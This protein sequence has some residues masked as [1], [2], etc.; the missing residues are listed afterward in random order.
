MDKRARPQS[1]KLPVNRGLNKNN[2]QSTNIT[3]QQ[4]FTN[5]RDLANVAEVRVGAN[6]GQGTLEKLKLTLTSAGYQ[7]RFLREDG[8]VVT[9][10]RRPMSGK[11]QINR[12]TQL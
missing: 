1:S 9:L 5:D 4:C 6:V 11:P 7:P 3:V 8:S 12:Q 10:N 2:S